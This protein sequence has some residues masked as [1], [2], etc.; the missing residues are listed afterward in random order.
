MKIYSDVYDRGNIITSY[1]ISWYL[2]KIIFDAYYPPLTHTR[3]H[4]HLHKNVTNFEGPET[5]FYVTLHL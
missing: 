2:K 3:I 5:E 4:K 1:I